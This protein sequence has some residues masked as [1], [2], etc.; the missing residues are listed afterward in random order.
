MSDEAPRK[1]FGKR[2]VTPPAIITHLPKGLP[3]SAAPDLVPDLAPELAAKMDLV[4]AVVIGLPL[5]LILGVIWLV[6][7]ARSDCLQSDSPQCLASGG[8]GSAVIR[9]ARSTGG[10]Y[11]V[12]FGGFGGSGGMHGGGS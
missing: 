9:V 8:G 6:E 1:T 3:P 11:G 5:L 2:G 4:F 7:A 12:S 10:G